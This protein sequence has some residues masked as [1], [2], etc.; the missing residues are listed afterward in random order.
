MARKQ[1]EISG[2]VAREELQA[3]LRN[4]LYK[5]QNSSLTP[6]PLVGVGKEFDLIVAVGTLILLCYESGYCPPKK[7]V[8]MWDLSGLLW[9][10]YTFGDK[11]SAARR[12]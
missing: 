2:L 10:F 11:P 6:F 8:K 5:L 12:R 9:H 4:K 7:N 1:L 3:S